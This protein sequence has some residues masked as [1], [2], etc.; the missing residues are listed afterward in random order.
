M[1]FSFISQLVARY[2]GQVA[3]WW[4]SG[5]EWPFWIWVA[6]G[7]AMAAGVGWAG[8][9]LVRRLLGHERINGAWIGREALAA[10]LDRLELRERDAGSMSI[11]DFRLLDRFRP[12][13]HDRL[14]KL[15]ERD[16]VS[17]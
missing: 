1:D 17:W 14:R 9:W 15:G 12:G 5:S 13:R 4:H 7:L 8:Y 2:S 3:A 10:V 16:Y 6:A 11:D